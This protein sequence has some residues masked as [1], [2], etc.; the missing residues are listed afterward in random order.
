METRTTNRPLLTVAQAAQFLNVTESGLRRMILE[1]RIP[2]YRVGK[3]V[4]FD[5]DQL[6]AF[7]TANARPAKSKGRDA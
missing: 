6:S 5:P 2:S 4:R 7:L 3:L 1:R